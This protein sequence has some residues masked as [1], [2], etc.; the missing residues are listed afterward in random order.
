MKARFLKGAKI[1]ELVGN[2]KDNLDRYR[3]GSF[4]FID[5]D[6]EFFLKQIL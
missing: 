5:I 6:P 2:I 1:K 3:T 4:D